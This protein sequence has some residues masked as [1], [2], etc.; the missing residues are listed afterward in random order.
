MEV[1]I[2]SKEDNSLI[3]KLFSLIK[4]DRQKAIVL[5]RNSPDR[6]IEYVVL[7]IKTDT[8]E[9]IKRLQNNYK[10]SKNGKLYRK[11]SQI[12]VFTVKNKSCYF[13]DAKNKIKHLTLAKALTFTADHIVSFILEKFPWFRNILDYVEDGSI[14]SSISFHWC[15][16][17]K[18]FNFID[19]IK[20]RYGLNRN[21][22]VLLKL[23]SPRDIKMYK[24]HI[25]YDN[26]N[27]DLFT[28]SRNNI[29]KNAYKNNDNVFAISTDIKPEMKNI[30]GKDHKIFKI[31]EHL[32]ISYSKNQMVKDSIELAYKL[33][34][35]VNLSWS[36]KRMKN[37]HDTMS[38]ILTNLILEM[39][40]RELLINPIFKKFEEYSGYDLLSTSKELAIE[41][42]KNKHCVATYAQ[43]VDS[44]KCAIYSIEGY[45]CEIQ[46]DTSNNLIIN[47]FKGNKNIEAPQEL[48]SEVN[49]IIHTFNQKNKTNETSKNGVLN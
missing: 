32:A 8:S 36:F 18:C 43:K 19:I 5:Y 42:F 28:D 35:K 3:K 30:H 13:I 2:L 31:P 22:L 24:D 34:T 44:G 23:L 38:A 4:T 11:T 12:Y 1:T 17:N 48:K 9:T 20:N 49:I 47:Q 29:V 39:E 15:E 41:G 21:N 6:F 33:N 27:L 45:T 40:N 26:I 25:I 16:K 7:R 37:E 14:L 10:I 46:K